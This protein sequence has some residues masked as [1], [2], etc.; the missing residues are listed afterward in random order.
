[1]LTARDSTLMEAA[2]ELFGELYDHRRPLRLMGVRF[3]DLSDGQAQAELFAENAR[4][5]QLLQQLDHIR[6]KFGESA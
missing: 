3:S 5:T 2:Q 1:P 4:E 6:K